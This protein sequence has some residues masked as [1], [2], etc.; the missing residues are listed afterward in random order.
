MHKC[1]CR[2]ERFN[3]LNYLCQI[4]SFCLFC[5]VISKNQALIDLFAYPNA[6]TT[7]HPLSPTA[8]VTQKMTEELKF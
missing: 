6:P 8:A 5:Q 4:G 3:W 7:P 1:T 2:S